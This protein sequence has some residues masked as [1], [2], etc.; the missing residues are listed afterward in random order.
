MDQLEWEMN[1]VSG[2]PRRTVLLGGYGSEDDQAVVVVCLLWHHFHLTMDY[3]IRILRARKE[4]M[5][6]GRGMIVEEGRWDGFA[7]TVAV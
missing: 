4:E 2:M 5:R 7:R 3:P 1:R 6:V